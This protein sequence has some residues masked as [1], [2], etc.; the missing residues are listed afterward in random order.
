MYIVVVSIFVKPEFLEPFK[1]ATLDNASN[2]RT[3]PR[4][5]RFDVIQHEDDPNRITLYEVYKN[6]DGFTAHQQTAHYA[7][8]KGAVGDWMAQP[9]MAVKGSPLFFDNNSL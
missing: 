4:N 6:K 7:R 9:R 8:W 3:E 5:L 1:A 2:T